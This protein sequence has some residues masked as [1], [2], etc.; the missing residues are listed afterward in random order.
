MTFVTRKNVPISGNLRIVADALADH[1]GYEIGVFKDGSV[2]DS[3]VQ[4]LQ[5]KGIVVF[6][7]F[8]FAALC[9]ILSSRTIFLSHSARDAF[10]THRRSGR[11]VINL[12][13]GVALKRIELMMKPFADIVKY[14]AR[15]KLI[16]K[17][18]RIYDAMIASSPVDRLVNSCA[19]GVSFDRVHVTGLP[20]FDYLDPSCSLPSDLDDQQK[21]LDSIL[22]G[23]HLILYAPTFRE[24][25]RSVF[26]YMDDECLKGLRSLCERGGLVFGIRPHPY[27]MSSLE[28]ICDGLHIVNLGSM[29]FPEPALL[30]N[31]TKVLV[32]DYSSIWVDYLIHK[33]P[34]LGFVPDL[35]NYTEHERGFIY[36]HETIFPGPVKKS[37]GEMISEIEIQ[38]ARN[39]ELPNLQHHSTTS[40]WLLP[41]VNE[42]QSC[43]DACIKL[44]FR[45]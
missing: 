12:W 3:T 34:I 37:W 14:E 4:A 18:A 21:K 17:N 41:P 40:A 5:A 39:F 31:R 38:F 33:R 13:H 10:L 29:V 22:H 24:S 36:S 7:G 26:H 43:T 16:E 9:F 32:V 23:R 44:F 1:G 20:R 8:S 30:L 42:N 6:A 15:K 11:R 19:F 45:D 27:D 28:R 25:G 35:E 2:P